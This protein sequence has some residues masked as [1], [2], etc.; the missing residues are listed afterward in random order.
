MTVILIADDHPLFREAL[1]GCV[2]SLLPQAQI[3]DADS[4]AALFAIVELHPGADLLL[5]LTMFMHRDSAPWCICVLRS[6][7]RC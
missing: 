5:Q 2:A 7:S 6:R 4:V 1:K 3:V